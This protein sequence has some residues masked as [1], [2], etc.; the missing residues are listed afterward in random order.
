MDIKMEDNNLLSL[1]Q[2]IELYDAQN[3]NAADSKIGNMSN[4]KNLKLDTQI[5]KEK[6]TINFLVRKRAN[7][8]KFG[9]KIYEFYNAPITKFWQ[10][11]IAY[12][13]FLIS[14]AYIVLV[15][16][17]P[18]ASWPEIFV[19]VYIFTY[20][21]D[22]IRELLQTDSPRFSGKIKIFFSR[23]M[24]TLD[25]FFILTIILALAFRIVPIKVKNYE[26]Y[27]AVARIIY[28]VN[29]IYWIVKLM[30]I[31]IINKYTG[32]LIIIAS[33]MVNC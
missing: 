13:L 10:N 5:S 21:A 20:G 33:R 28:C 23:I 17:P 4:S 2:I 14:F 19:L 7:K 16:T 24:N 15:K 8:L 18:K 22:K 25:I 26:Q 32:P 30:E 31:L 3:F 11:T 6:K 29:T 27:H 9:K 1:D 12:I